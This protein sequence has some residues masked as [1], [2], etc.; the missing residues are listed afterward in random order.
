MKARLD[1]VK[2][3]YQDCLTVRLQCLWQMYGKGYGPMRLS[4]A[5]RI[6]QAKSYLRT[7]YQKA[8]CKLKKATHS[9][10]TAAP[11]VYYLLAKYM[12]ELEKVESRGAYKELKVYLNSF[13]LQ[14][15]M[16][17]RYLAKALCLHAEVET[18]AGHY[19]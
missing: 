7:N 2:L 13:G 16:D 18:V 8:I 6:L 11:I 4:D 17:E 5:Y 3:V 14:R 10:R 15:D 1:S 9:G 19:E 12:L